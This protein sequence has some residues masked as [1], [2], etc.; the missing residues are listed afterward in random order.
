MSEG[1]PSS[2]PSPR[3]TRVEPEETEIELRL[4]AIRKD[5]ALKNHPLLAELEWLGAKHI[6]LIRR[7]MKI[8][9][10]SDGFQRELKNL[11]TTLQESSRTDYL[12]GLSNRREMME[13][14]KA[15]MSRTKRG[16]LP[17]AVL[18]ADVDRFKVVN[19]TFGHEAGDL[20][21]QAIAANL[22]TA[23]REYDVCSRW[24]GEEFLVLLPE[25][26]LE[27]ASAVGEKL[28]ERVSMIEVDHEGKC[29][30][31]TISLGLASFHR[32]ET[33]TSLLHRADEA[34]Y[35]A[36]R[37]GRDRMEVAP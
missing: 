21:L 28:R 10:I 19:D 16:Q 7:F 23:L 35:V 15:E 30:G 1:Q 8:S 20:L 9:R 4:E 34:M 36:K 5:P 13:R 6:R 14:L 29:L 24:G 33:L 27:D 17:L 37:M 31:A 3:H 32:D 26:S 11:N 25:T 2:H 18:M 12:T 22:R